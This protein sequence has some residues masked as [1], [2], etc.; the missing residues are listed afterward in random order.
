MTYSFH[1]DN[2]NKTIKVLHVDDENSHLM[3]TKHYIEDY[4]TN[5]EIFS[6]LS[7]VDALNLDLPSFDCIL[8]DYSMPK[9]TG[10]DFAVEVKKN[11]AIPF[12]L[13]TGRG[14]DEV[15]AEAYAMGID[16]YQRKEPN[17]SHFRVLAK[18]IKNL[19]EKNRA[20]AELRASWN[21][22][23]ELIENFPSGLF[24]Y[25]F[26]EPDRLVLTYSNSVAEALTGVSIEDSLGSEYLDIWG[27]RK[28]VDMKGVLI[29]CIKLDKPYRSNGFHFNENG[30]D[31]YL[32]ISAFPL[33]D[34]RIVVSFEN[35]TERV[36]YETRLEALLHHIIE[37]DQ[38]R[39]IGEIARIG[40]RLLN[41]TLGFN[42]GRFYTRKQDGFSL[43]LADSERSVTCEGLP[44][45]VLEVF[46]S[47][48]STRQSMDHGVNRIML[49]VPITIDDTVKCVL[50]VKNKNSTMVS[51]QDINLV[52]ILSIQ[53]SSA[54]RRM[55]EV[56]RLEKLV[57]KRTRKLLDNERLVTAGKVISMM[58]HD[59]RSPLQSIVNSIYILK[60]DPGSWES[61]FP[62]IEDSANYAIK[63][64]E[65]L[66][67]LTKRSPV[68][69]FPTDIGVIIKQSVESN[70][71]PDDIIVCV[72]VD[73][74]LGLIEVDPVQIRRVL[75]NL[76]SNA[77]DAMPMGGE[78]TV[79]VERR[80]NSVLLSVTDN[81]TGIDSSVE[82]VLFEL[83]HTTKPNGTG[84]GLA[85]CKR[86]VEA[87]DGIISV[88]NNKQEGASFNI[89]LPYNQP[90]T[91]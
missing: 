66:Q 31:K 74:G 23:S 90:E 69:K 9:M 28:G 42:S 54:I 73:P 20:V 75:D 68:R 64:L 11:H 57:N 25:Q 33:S 13:Y 89:Y 59:L 53:I 71:I 80:V 63:I 3:L 19:V 36:K 38:A 56:E 50:C 82:P 18:R 49:A 7:V 22:S 65:D 79:R 72:D 8:S 5:I 17:I 34:S 84:L 12:I 67:H 32:R 76:I 48:Q 87:H 37:L 60:N 41:E 62:R 39:S 83:F 24:I 2:S 6:Q 29:N 52:E 85:F 27:S 77:V 55:F 30:R 15:S 14:S 43:I 10:I 44:D 35:I 47:G 40:F 86:A 26:M 51:C 81:G 91:S 88:E 46:L 4:A 16:S 70:R 58:G 21:T 45:I 61:F 78:L 1:R